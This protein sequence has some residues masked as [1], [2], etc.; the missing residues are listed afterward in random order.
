MRA[1]ITHCQHATRICAAFQIQLET[2]NNNKKLM[3]HTRAHESFSRT[4]FRTAEAL[5]ASLRLL[6]CLIHRNAKL[7]MQ[8]NHLH[9]VVCSILSM[10]R[11]T[12]IMRFCMRWVRTRIECSSLPNSPR[13]SSATSTTDASCRST[14]ASVLFAI[15]VKSS[16]WFCC[17]CCFGC[18]CCCC[19]CSCCWLDRC[20]VDSSSVV[21]FCV[22]RDKNT[23]SIMRWTNGI[24]Y[25]ASI[26]STTLA[27]KFNLQCAPSR[28]NSKQRERGRE[29]DEKRINIFSER[30]FCGRGQ[31]VL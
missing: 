31:I 12:V 26:L 16:Y 9:I 29:I 17:F 11:P 18:C 13:I 10:L 19:S 27:S 21:D 20:D 4:H 1:R 5:C 22:G 3:W 7:Y 15:V 25:F 8:L 30:W 6:F 24:F 23:G 2:R 14:L 28:P